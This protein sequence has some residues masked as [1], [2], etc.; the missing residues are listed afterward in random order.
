MAI[1]PITIWGEPV[2]HNPAKPVT[3]F[4]DNLKKL[5]NDMY[6]T[7][8]AAPGV[9]L[10][11]PQIGLNKRLFTY[12]WTNPETG[13]EHRGVAVNPVLWISPLPKGPVDLDKDQEGCLSVPG[14]RYPTKRAERALLRAYDLNNEPFEIE[15]SGW[16]ARILQHEYDHLNG[17]IYVDRLD[18]VQQ[19]KA[20]KEIAKLG[21]GKPGNTWL[22]GK[23]HLEGNETSATSFSQ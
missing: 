18:F 15:A 1:L 2:L 7:M 22:P 14:E 23:D 3:E 8:D 12:G 16:F 13:E 6:E 17:I 19:R 21:W 4:D 11:A 10:A 5:V 9:G 20:L